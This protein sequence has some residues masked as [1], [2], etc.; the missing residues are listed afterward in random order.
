MATIPPSQRFRKAHPCPICNRHDDAPRGQGARCYGFLS[1]DGTFAHCTS[2]DFAGALAKNPKSDT[3]A[4]RLE[5]DCRCGVRHDPSPPPQRQRSGRRQVATYNYTDEQGTLLYQVVRYVNAD[6]SKTFKQRRPDGKGGSVWNLKGVRRVPYRLPELLSAVQSDAGLI[7]VVE[8]EKDVDRL[9]ALS[10]PA[11]CNPG[12]AR[13]WRHDFADYFRGALMVVVLADNDDEGRQ[14]AQQVC[15]SL[16]RTVRTVKRH[17]F[18]DL[19]KGGDVS[20]WLDAGHTAEDLEALLTQAPSVTAEDTSPT[21]AEAVEANS[22][23]A[24]PLVVLTNDRPMRWA[25]EDALK[26]WVEANTPPQN[27]V[28]G[29]LL[30]RVR[31]NEQGYP[32]IDTLGE[33]HV[34]GA[35]MRAVDIG[36]WETRKDN[37][38]ELVDVFKHDTPPATMVKDI[39]A[40]GSWDFPALEAVTEIPLMRPDG[41]LLD[42]P[43]Y[44]PTLRLYYVPPAGFRLAPVP[45]QPVA[46][47]VNRALKLIWETIGE[48][49]YVDDGPELDVDGRRQRVSASR[50]NAMAALLTPVVR[51]LIRGCVP[52]ALIDKPAAGTG[53]SLFM[54]VLALITT[55][56]SVGFLA[57]PDKEEEWRKSITATLKDGAMLVIID[58]VEKPLWAPSLAMALTTD[59]WK[60]RELATS[61]L[62]QLPQRATWFA[63][64]NNIKLRGDLPRRCYWVRMDAKMSQPWTRPPERF[65]HPDL[66]TWATDHRGELLAALLT[67]VRAWHV[68]GRPRV[69]VPIL[70]GFTSWADTLGS[71][72]AYLQVPGFLANLAAFYAQ[73]DEEG[74]QCEAFLTAWALVFDAAPVTVATLVQQLG[75]EASPLLEAVPEELMDAI[76][77]AGDS[78]ASFQRKLG[79]ALAKREGVRYGAKNLYVTRAGVTH[80]A[81]RWHVQWTEP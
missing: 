25:I 78:W 26:Y 69:K 31:T 63:T 2:D 3:Y 53:A 14:H 65:T 12:G 43:G 56:R 28:R 22:S 51:P 29:G 59:V 73:A 48:F 76:P 6:G 50:A 66:L 16:L 46:H 19:P 18:T 23:S 40:R 47:D 60:D 17:D 39:L 58:N 35:L 42:E 33:A 30:A 41:S 52:L 13:K 80:Q 57:A 24:L 11:T 45:E 67:L 34:A 5:G 37:H 10:Y 44:D 75:T 61:H 21:E 62:L 72:L 32:I 81:T 74:P 36:H 79:R 64:G 54:Q 7:L 4:H 68:A 49:P 1:H 20:D 15:T 27:F 77:A 70:G 71:L 38:G 55:G 9:R 8:G